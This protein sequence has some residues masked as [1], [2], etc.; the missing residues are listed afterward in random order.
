MSH[1]WGDVNQDGV[2]DFSD[3]SD[4]IAI[5]IAGGYQVEADI[6]E[7]GFVNFSDIDPFILIL[8]G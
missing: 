2:V 3:I 1:F 4:F 8:I 7:D 6:N 5:L